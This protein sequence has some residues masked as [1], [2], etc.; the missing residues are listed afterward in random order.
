MHQHWLEVVCKPRITVGA[1]PHACLTIAKQPPTRIR[2]VK[3]LP[4]S[5]RYFVDADHV[6]CRPVARFHHAQC[7]TA[8]WK[9]AYESCI[10]V[11]AIYDACL[12]ITKQSPT[13]TF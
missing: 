3:V 11:A 10:T 5:C 12:T 8:R 6:T 7:T 9:V 2:Y 4:N 13:R 1:T